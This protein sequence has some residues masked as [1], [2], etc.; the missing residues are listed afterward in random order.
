MDMMGVKAEGRTGEDSDFVLFDSS[1]VYKVEMWQPSK[2][3]KKVPLVKTKHGN[4]V[5]IQSLEGYVVL[6]G[7]EGFTHLDNVNVVNVNNV[8][9][10]VQTKFYIRAYFED[11]TF[12]SVSKANLSKVEHLPTKKPHE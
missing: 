10:I 5:S 1:D 9:Y 12:A 6:L 4:Y 8:K 3:A 2:N 7:D 11:G